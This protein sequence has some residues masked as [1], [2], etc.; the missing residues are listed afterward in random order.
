MK[1][2]ATCASEKSVNFQRYA[3]RYIP[4]DKTFRIY[5]D[6]NKFLLTSFL[7]MTK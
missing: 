6:F 5:E 7:I 2:E 1:M 4:E 3:Q